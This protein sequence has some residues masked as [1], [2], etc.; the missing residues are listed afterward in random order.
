MGRAF[1]GKELGKYATEL[2]RMYL[3]PKRKKGRNWCCDE[4]VYL[5][6]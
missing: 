6:Q 5:V 4:A 1:S 2:L 3:A